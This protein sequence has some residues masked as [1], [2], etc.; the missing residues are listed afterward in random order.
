MLLYTESHPRPWR[1]CCRITADKVNQNIQFTFPFT[2]RELNVL[3]GKQYSLL[4]LV[5][6][7]FY[8]NLSRNV[9]VVFIFD[10][11]DE[12]RLPLDFS[13][14]QILSD[15]TESMCCWQASSTASLC[16]WQ[17]HLCGSDLSVGHMLKSSSLILP[18]NVVF[19]PN[20][21]CHYCTE[22]QP[23]PPRKNCKI[24]AMTGDSHRKLRHII[25]NY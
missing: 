13:H 15:V 12:C 17:F 25:L 23:H 14:H 18:L 3:K 11:L 5:H 10:I 6:H 21:W 1:K 4:E 9:Q 2:F 8:W 22:L 19:V 20:M 7:F 24:T 16:L